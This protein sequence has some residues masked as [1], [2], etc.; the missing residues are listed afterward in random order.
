M[1]NP[2]KKV[3]TTSVDQIRAAFHERMHANHMYGL[4]EL[5]SQ[6]T[7][8]PQAKMIAYMWQWSRPKSIIDE[9]GSAVPGR[10]GKNMKNPKFKAR[11]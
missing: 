9:S 11:W 7:P 6:M 1:A 3:P 4:W 10:M 5:A 8:Y 2:Q